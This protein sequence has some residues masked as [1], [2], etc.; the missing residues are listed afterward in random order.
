MSSCLAIN[1]AKRTSWPSRISRSVPATSGPAGRRRGPAGIVASRC[2]P[3]AP[4]GSDTAINTPALASTAWTWAL[5]PDPSRPAWPDS[6]PA[7]VIPGWPVGRSRPSAVGP[8]A[9]DRRDHRRRAHRF[10]STV[11][12]PLDSQWVCQMHLRSVGLQH[13]DRPV[14]SVGCFEHHLGVGAGVLSCSPNATGLL[15]IRTAESCSPDSVWRTITDRC[16]CRSIRRTARRHTR[17]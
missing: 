16:R 9:A 8:S 4:N 15:T 1:A 7:R 5:S 10:Q 13:V 3:V 14:P 12:K 11:A 6:A 2:R 17:S